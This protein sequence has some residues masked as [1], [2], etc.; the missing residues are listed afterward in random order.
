MKL[1]TALIL[2]SLLGLVSCGKSS[3]SGSRKLEGNNQQ[4]EE[5]PSGPI[6]NTVQ[7][8]DPTYKTKYEELPLEGK[9]EASDRLWSGD[10]WPS[11]RGLI[12]RRWNTTDEVGF[13]Y[14]SPTKEELAVMGEVELARLSATEKYDLL[15]GRYDYPLKKEVASKAAP[16]A[17]NW[18][19]LGNGWAAASANH[20]EPTAKLLLNPDGLAIPFGSSDIKALLSYYYA[21]VNKLPSSHYLGLR[22]P[23]TADG[24]RPD[25]QCTNDLNAGS[26]HIVLGN[27]IGIRREIFVADVDRFQEVWNHPFLGFKSEVVE[28]L[29][30]IAGNPS[31]TAKIFRMKTKVSYTD[32][33]VNTWEPLKGTPRQ[34]TTNR[35]YNYD[36][37][38]N[39]EG[40]IIGGEW[41]SSDRPDFI[42]VMP[43]VETFVGFEGLVPLLN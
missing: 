43:M 3:K 1:F 30:A 26:F 35:L 40:H 16:F 39:A 22:C 24:S 36:L 41:I 5:T 32:K 9:V 21:F 42:W 14:V 13:D 23:V 6:I 29:P 25:E 12:N 27:K 17:V 8:M 20:N 38:I 4:G 18:E 34:I 33:T 37:Y 15:M 7:L 10:Y 2:A 11:N 31:G 28:T 19:G